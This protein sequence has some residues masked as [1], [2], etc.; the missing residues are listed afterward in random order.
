MTITGWDL[1][2]TL[3]TL[4]LVVAGAFWLKYAIDAQLKS[5]GR[6]KYRRK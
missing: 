5:K 1:I 4:A 2:L 6:N 3:M